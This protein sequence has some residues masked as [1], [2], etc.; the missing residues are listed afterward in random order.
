[1]S[2]PISLDIMVNPLGEVQIRIDD[3]NVHSRF[4]HIHEEPTNIT[5]NPFSLTTAKNGWNEQ[6]SSS[7]SRGC[8]AAVGAVY[9]IYVK[10]PYDLTVGNFRAFSNTSETKTKVAAGAIVIFASLYTLMLYGT[11]FHLQGRILQTLGSKAGIAALSKTGEMLKNLGTKIF[12]AGAVPVYGVFYA[13]PK[14]L[15]LSLPKIVKEVAAKITQLAGWIFHNVLQPL[16]EN[17]IAPVGEA[18]ARALNFAAAK[19]GAALKVIGNKIAALAKSLFDHVLKP[20]WE[21]VLFPVLHGLA[22][23]VQNIAIA[24]GSAVK[25]IGIKIT[26]AVRILFQYVIAPFWNRLVMPLVKG[27]ANAI[28]YLA[29]GIGQV[30]QKVAQSA[31]WIFR[32]LIIPVWN[33]LIHPI[34]KAAGN[35][36]HFVCRVLAESIKELALATGKAAAFIFHKLIAPVFKAIANVVLEAGKLLVNY[37]IKPLIYVLAS[38]AEKVAYVFKAVFAG[39]IVPAAKGAA[40]CAAFLKD[41]AVDLTTEIW[42]SVTAIWNQVASR[43]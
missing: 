42:H 39:I 21:K 37:V 22:K 32:N 30:A 34:L 23:V 12:V 28:V 15:I 10:N 5:Y 26:Q 33:K 1:M 29:K 19:I 41:S 16:W 36:I 17:V 35:V 24:V 25:A 2:M 4:P 6:N 43:F 40:S 14:Q 20:L 7:I 31:Q 13:L 11:T 18:V 38:V 3:Q 8:K 27:I 9:D